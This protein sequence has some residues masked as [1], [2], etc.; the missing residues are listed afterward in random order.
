MVTAD[1]TAQNEHISVELTTRCNSQC[2]HCFVRTNL[3]KD[4]TLPLQT[5]KD[6]MVEGHALGYQSLHLTG[7]EPLLWDGLWE[8]LDFA[9]ALGYRQL[10]I[11]SNGTQLSADFSR[12][13][14][15]YPGISLSVSL[16]GPRKQHDAMRGQGSFNQAIR[17]IENALDAR[18]PLYVFT[19]VTR[20][21]LP[22]LPKFS[23][24]LFNNASGIK[25]LTL[26]QLIRVAGHPKELLEELLTP[27]DFIK[28]VKIAALLN[29]CGYPTEILNNPLA[30]VVSK[31]LELP[32]L[33]PTFP[34]IRKNHI[35]VMADGEIS[36]T[37]SS[38]QRFGRYKKGTLSKVLSSTQFQSSVRPDESVCPT[39][40]FR[41]HCRKYGMLMPAE[42]FRDLR[43]DSPYCK[44]VINRIHKAKQNQ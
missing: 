23:H 11:N 3:K 43:T 35:I 34:L 18:I 15:R 5:V 27:S 16:Q 19:T 6:V 13:L 1:K 41:I 8:S 22:L 32:W 44:R 20:Q 2:R 26:I 39:C 38:R 40:L 36:L 10:F 28:L 17:G 24:W 33:A 31:L 37:H 42:W 9:S 30:A 29:R 12:R 14:S 7:G 25:R 21:L 4:A